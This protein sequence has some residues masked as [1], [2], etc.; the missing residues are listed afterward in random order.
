MTTFSVPIEVGASPD[1]PFER[2]EAAV[3][4]GAFYSWFPRPLLERLGIGPHATRSF[5]LAT[6]EEIL[7]D[8][9]RAWIRISDQREMTIVVF[10][11]ERSEPLL[12]AVTLEE[13]AL[14]ADPVNERLV[15]STRLR[16][17]HAEIGDQKE[18][19]PQWT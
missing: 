16:M 15:P 3:D 1:G 7:R 13:F 8:A 9:G 11:D 19:R 17:L 4:T 2:V 10:G 12:G 14:A 6:G 18:V 5:V